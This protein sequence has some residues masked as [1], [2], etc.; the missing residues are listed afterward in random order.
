MFASMMATALLATSVVSVANADFT[1][2]DGYYKEAVDALCEQGA[3]D[4]EG[5]FNGA[6]QATR[7][8][9]V[10]LLMSGGDKPSIGFEESVFDDVPL[11]HQ[12][13]YDI[14]LAYDLGLI[15]GDTDS[16]GN[17]L[18]TFRP[19][20]PINRAELMTIVAATSSIEVEECTS[21]YFPDVDPEDWFCSFV[22][23]AFWNSIVNG[24]GDGTFGP[25]KNVLR[26][27]V[28]VIAYQAQ[29]PVYRTEADLPEITV[30]TSETID[31]SIEP[32]AYEGETTL[33]VPYD[34]ALSDLA[35][36]DYKNTR[37]GDIYYK[38]ALPA[39]DGTQ[40][41]GM[42]GL[43]VSVVPTGDGKYQFEQGIW[44]EEPLACR[45]ENRSLI[46]STGLNYENA[47]FDGYDDGYADYESILIVADTSAAASYGDLS[48][49]YLDGYNWGWEGNN[50]VIAQ[51]YI[52]SHTAAE[53]ADSSFTTDQL[54]DFDNDGWRIAKDD[55]LDGFSFEYSYPAAVTPAYDPDS[56]F[57][58][59][60]NDH[61]ATYTLNV[62]SAKDELESGLNSSFDLGGLKKIHF[63][64][65][66]TGGLDDFNAS[67]TDV[68]EYLTEFADFIG[69]SLVAAGPEVAATC[70]AYDA[71]NPYF[72]GQLGSEFEGF[73]YETEVVEFG[74]NTAV[75]LTNRYICLGEEYN[76]DAEFYADK[77][78][79]VYN[80][81][82][83]E[84]Y[85][86][87][88]EDENLVTL[89]VVFENETNLED[90]GL[91]SMKG[92]DFYDVDFL[93]Q[94][95]AKMDGVL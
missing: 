62:G 52:C 78:E 54:A 69:S 85:Y 57:N 1:D 41:V 20:D 95:V 80:L 12:Y 19:D 72:E 47:W 24:F 18:G 63:S 31:T 67:N 39:P 49:V 58:D 83:Q 15:V 40:V 66:N 44:W 59:G 10:N 71:N 23:A 5:E 64:E 13:A 25:A 38:G 87:L 92:E 88:T 76:E 21:S 7:G 60:T 29:T 42:V 8:F 27:D 68:G 46:G 45:D 17:L 36:V 3:L 30:E 33:E 89:S 11:S 86:M 75:R 37:H 61:L 73:G 26:Q 48:D 65:I 28:A 56:P 35:A 22:E 2:V 53:V 77:F 14:N 74:S 79:T 93:E 4:C 55:Y 32:T 81:W 82:L 34:T 90:G 70:F 91:G 16:E 84:T 6:Q 9:V 43:N 94:F 50:S 51:S